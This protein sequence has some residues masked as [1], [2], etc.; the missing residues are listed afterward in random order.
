MHPEHKP[1]RPSY[2]LFLRDNSGFGNEWDE[3]LV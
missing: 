1:Y 3:Y 2:A